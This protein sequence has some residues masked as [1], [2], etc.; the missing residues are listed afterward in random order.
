[1]R[2]IHFRRGRSGRGGSTPHRPG[3]H[4]AARRRA[5][6]A[7]GGSGRRP[8]V[9]GIQ[10]TRSCP[11]FA[12]FG[13]SIDHA[14]AALRRRPMMCLRP[15]PDLVPAG[16][17]RA[18]RRASGSS[19]RAGRCAISRPGSPPHRRRAVPDGHQCRVGHRQG[20]DR[21]GE[22]RRG[23][24]GRAVFVPVNCAV[25][26]DELFESEMFGHAR[27]A[28]TGASQDRKGLLELSS[29][30]TVFPDEAAELTPRAQA[31]LLRVLQ[32]GEIRRLGEN[33][34]ER[35]DLRVVAAT[36]R[37]LDAEAA[38]GRF[39][40]DL[41]YRLKV[42]RLTA[43][44]RDRG[45]DVAG[46][47]DHC[48]KD[49]AAAAGSRATLARETVGR[50]GGAP[51]ARQRRRAAERARQPAWPPLAHARSVGVHCRSCPNPA[52]LRRPDSPRHRGFRSHRAPD[53]A[54]WGGRRVIP[55]GFRRLL[56]K[57]RYGIGI[58]QVSHGNA[59]DR[60][61][62]RTVEGGLESPDVAN[63][64]RAAVR[65]QRD[66]TSL[67]LRPDVRARHSTAAIRCPLTEEVNAWSSIATA[68][69]G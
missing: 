34:T 15:V 5:D 17:R 45:P 69:K 40:S 4:S 13:D 63:G 19:A 52:P 60:A 41:L 25:L 33:R 14:P 62:D 57:Y 55:P 20:A 27:G 59:P 21:P 66:F 26:G 1:M 49:I 44:L 22:P 43:P 42:L 3:R 58:R 10:P 29:G 7:G 6:P 53:G 54:E 67:E 50:P 61:I 48:W 36:N 24:R 12:S 38:A 32:D 8:R 56:T 30:G 65:R 23:P 39:R 46:L 35:L 68:I 28:F 51:V 2:S 16:G 11:V 37:P 64:M 9:S 31:R 47:T 18:A